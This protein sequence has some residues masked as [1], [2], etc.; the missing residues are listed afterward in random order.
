MY[1]IWIASPV[2]Y[3]Y[4][5]CFL[6]VAHALHGALGELGHRAEITRGPTV[7][8]GENRTIILGANLLPGATLP[9]NS[10]IYNLETIQDGMLWCTEGYLDLL[11]QHEV[12]DFSPR[13][14]IELG[15]RGVAAKYCGV[16]YHEYLTKIPPD[17]E[18]IDVVFAGAINP[19]RAK[20]FDEM[21]A[22]GISLVVVNSG[23]YAGGRDSMIARAKI[24]LNL[25][26]YENKEFEIVRCSY[27]MANKKCIVSEYGADKELESP[28]YPG[29]KFCDYD[30]IIETCKQLLNEPEERKTLAEAGFN[31]FS[32]KRQSQYL[33]EL[34]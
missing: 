25:H 26:F 33:K 24:C 28:F 1:N 2:D 10:I 3:P 29:I 20:I 6:E 8:L 11:R 13:N 30:K 15:K 19:R 23:H 12:W 5:G 16:G 32:E 18:D 4:S 27:L 14:V 22:S 17:E 7:P 34:L 31:I 21:V 9:E